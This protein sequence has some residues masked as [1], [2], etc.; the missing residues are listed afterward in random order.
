M[1]WLWILLA[2]ALTMV[3]LVLLG[4]LAVGQFLFL[5]RKIHYR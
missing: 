1:I 3:L 5:D 2:A 4:L